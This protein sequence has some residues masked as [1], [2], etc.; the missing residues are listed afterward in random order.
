MSVRRGGGLRAN[1]EKA[2]PSRIA[3]SVAEEFARVKRA[4]G[5]VY[6]DPLLSELKLRPPWPLRDGQRG[7]QI[8]ASHG[9]TARGV[10]TGD[11]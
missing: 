6:S 10:A 8:P 9:P 2:G 11:W 1:D 3:R 4:I 7:Q 5:R